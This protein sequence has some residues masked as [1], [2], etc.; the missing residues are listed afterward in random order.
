MQF[1]LQICDIRSFL[2]TVFISSTI[3]KCYHSVITVYHRKVMQISVEL[4]CLKQKRSKEVKKCYIFFPLCF[5]YT[6]TPYQR[7]FT[8]TNLQDKSDS[9]LYFPNFHYFCHGNMKNNNESIQSVYPKSDITYFSVT[10]SYIVV[11][12]LLKTYQ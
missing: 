3:C 4:Q 9:I 7:I 6:I 5:C 12:K 8:K 1:S 11:L 10:Q 2:T